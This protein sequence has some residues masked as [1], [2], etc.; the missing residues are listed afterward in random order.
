MKLIF[1]I[2]FFL[3]LF[4]KLNTAIA[5]SIIYSELNCIGVARI[6]DEIYISNWDLNFTKPTQANLKILYANKKKEAPLRVS[7]QKNGDFVANGKWKSQ[8]VQ[9]SR[10]VRINYF[11]HINTMKIG[12]RFGFRA[13]GKCK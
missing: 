2:I 6:N 3:M 9:G 8:K 7:I 5:N 10:F 13:E 1:T 4:T 11:K 12:F